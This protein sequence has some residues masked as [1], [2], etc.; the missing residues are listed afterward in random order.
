LILL[1]N[2]ITI[3]IFLILSRISTATDYYIS[4]SGNDSNNGKSSST[5]WKTIAKVNASSFLPGDQI[6]FNKGDSWAEN[7]RPS[8]SGTAAN[9]I[10]FSSYG[11]GNLPVICGTSVISA[12]WLIGKPYIIIDGFK[13]I[14]NKI[15]STD[16]SIKANIAYGITVNNS[17]NT[18]IRNCDISLV[19][20]GIDLSVNSTNVTI[21]NNYIHNLRMVVND[22][23][24]GNDWGAV[25]VI[26]ETSSNTL[27]HNTFDECWAPS[28][29]YKYDGGVI[30]FFGR[31]MSNNLIAY[32]KATNCN[33]FLEIGSSNGAGVANN[34]VIAYNIIN[35]C[36]I[37]GSYHTTDGLSTSTS[38]LQYYNNVVI[39]T[40]LQYTKPGV[41]FYSP[42]ACP[43]GMLV[44]KNNIFWLSDGTDITQ[45]GL[46]SGQMTHTNNIYRMSSGTTGLT[47][48]STETLSTNASLFVST[49]GDPSTWNLHPVSG[50]PAINAG[51]SVGL[52]SDFDGST[53]NNPPSIGVYESVST[54]PEVPVYVNS[55]VA[56][57]TP[58]LLE[59]T[60][61]IALA[62]YIPAT[63]AFS[64]LVNS[65]ARSVNKV[66]I[67]GT[68]VQLTLSSPIVNGDVV[69]V[70][71]NKPSSNPLQTASAGLAASLS[72][73]TV[74]NGVTA[75]IPVYVSSAVANATPSLLEMTYNLALANYIPAASAFSVSVNSVARTVN[76]VAISGT[77]VQLTLASPIVYGNVVTVTYTKPSANPLQTASAGQAASLSAQVVTNGV[78]G[79]IPV[80]VSS[81]VV[82][83]TPSLLE[84]TYNLA[85][86]NYIPATSAFS[87]QVNS[88]VRTINSVAISGT[89]VQLT[90]ASPIVYGD[91]VTVAYNKPSVNP[92]QTATA[93]Q[94]ASLSGQTVVNRVTAIPVYVSSVVANATPSLLEMT[95]NLALANYVPATSAFSVLVNSAARTVNRVA[96]SGT[97][98]Q[99][100]LA[101]TIVYGDVVTVAYTKPSVNPLQ[102]ASAGEAV[103]FSAQTVA[104][105]VTGTIPVYVSSAVANAT[106]S[107]LEMTYNF[108]L[109]NYIPA[110]S[111]FSVLVNSAV[112]SVNSVA[113]S[114][115]K[116]LLT[117][118]SPIIY[119]DV[120][121]VA[122]TKPSTNPLQTASAGQAASLSAQTVVNGV[123]AI[124]VYVSSVVANATP[125]LLEMTFNLALANYIPASSAFSVQVN[126]AA[127]TVN[128]VAISGTKVQLTLA[129]PVIYGDVVTVAYAK[130]STN[131]LQTASGGQAASL[132]AQTVVNR[133]TSIPI[134]VSSAV[135]NATPSLLE[136]TYNLVLANFIPAA[137]AFSVH[138][139][140]APR[141]VNRV[142]ISGTKVQ[143]TLVSP[144]VYGDVVTV[145]YTKPSNNPLQT[146]SAGQAAS[147]SEQTVVNGV[148][149]IPVYVSSVVAN[150]TPSLLEMTYNLALANYIP[151]TSA[152][153]V[154]VNSAART[155]NRVSISGTKVQLTLAS[156]IIYG[157][158]VTVAYTRPSANPLQTAS[159][160]QAASLS[161]QT[162]TNG[163]TGTILV[164]VS[165]AV[166]NAT[167]SLLEMTYNIALADY[168]PSTSA[169]SVQVNSA[170]RPINS[171][172]ISGTKV[173]L[174]LASPIV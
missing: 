5:P 119:G 123:G 69:T 127:R 21:I 81:V 147:L 161:A 29:D 133:V 76:R 140:S 131:P 146:A 47:L 44:V 158:A 167:P 112:R 115:T 13:I 89:I 33:G 51:V 10:T 82:N 117:L 72:A 18:I 101:S 68:K 54:T 55:V 20:C 97:K 145:A 37:I 62:N 126:S 48:T 17:S 160:G 93:Q 94:A 109:A 42:G 2:S 136:M 135:A 111:T 1:K 87:V 63:S 22:N 30:E 86:A 58:S 156:P 170:V 116:V 152:F 7:L 26:V 150:A 57:A 129:S 163:V 14:D 49:S 91:I 70:S 32:N 19:G 92:L 110:T 122:Y 143:L 159:A 61:N 171:V 95:Y 142:A 56:N 4:S 53:L 168:I 130:P 71:Y 36:G 141:T 46:N 118:A 107:L 155:V 174:T 43:A 165:S 100:T 11:T 164:Y 83:A 59:M 84:M 34:N 3:F 64:V 66:V 120:V 16:H 25:A 78:T 157:D 104:N 75:E 39:Q 12:I 15:S 166:A 9:P 6:L 90:L 134:Y 148:T 154:R 138:V 102:T 132:S 8:S 169:F 74:A 103:S 172:A 144:I 45:S 85:L 28:F 77:K 173:Q 88:T 149:A 128:T 108:A 121:T 98:V 23:S 73:Q 52:T 38:N 137:S 139:N 80:Y 24:G 35:N 99:L 114:G 153:S 124:P 50:S 151:S 106:P 113:I 40:V 41:L 67:S 31:E 79:A 96:I 162:V 125:S 105:G 60:Y 27:T 65:S